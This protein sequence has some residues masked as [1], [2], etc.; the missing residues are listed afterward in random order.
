MA[1]DAPQGLS[2]VLHRLGEELRGLAGL[3]DGALERVAAV[4]AAAGEAGAEVATIAARLEDAAAG[5]GSASERIRS[6]L[7]TTR[8]AVAAGS[9]AVLA[10]TETLRQGAADAF[11]DLRQRLT[12]GSGEFSDEI[13][14]AVAAVE[15]GAVGMQEFLR[16]WGDAVLA[17]ED[18]SKR[19]REV[20]EDLDLGSRQREIQEL[21][22]DFERGVAGIDEVTAKL[23]ESG[24]DVAQRLAD[25]V[26]SFRQ[27]RVTAERLLE[28]IR[29]VQAQFPDTELADLA[30][31]IAD[32][33]RKGQL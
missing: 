25:M 4:R 19:V 6:E 16:T 3:A 22:R 15:A 33:A 9:A 18:G 31:A 5:V 2:A 1:G 17:T 27:G 30:E 26:E 11:D 24:F 12:Q 20:L 14:R 10:E 29:G 28:L 7:E 32:A 23:A 8:E 21:I 13:R